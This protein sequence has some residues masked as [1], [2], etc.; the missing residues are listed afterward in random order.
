MKLHEAAEILGISLEEVT[1][2]ILKTTFKKLTMSFD[3]EKVVQTFVIYCNYLL[4][5]L[6]IR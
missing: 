4:L 2:D 1:P 3:A 6:S 5:Y